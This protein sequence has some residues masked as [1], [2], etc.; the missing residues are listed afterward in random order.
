MKESKRT[1]LTIILV[2]TVSLLV[3]AAIVYYTVTTNEKYKDQRYE[4][5]FLTSSSPQRIDSESHYFFPD[6]EED[7]PR[8]LLQALLDGPESTQLVSPFPEDLQIVNVSVLGDTLSV[9]FSEHY[10][11][12]DPY[13]RNLADC[14]L[15][16]TVSALPE[17]RQVF[18]RSSDSQAPALLTADRFLASDR[19]FVTA[20]REF[21]L[22]Y[23]NAAFTALQNIS[24]PYRIHFGQSEIETVLDL[25]EHE[26]FP[27][28]ADIPLPSPLVNDAL[29]YDNVAHVDLSADLLIIQESVDADEY[30][31]RIRQNSVYLRAIV[32]TLVSL[33]DIGSVMFTF[34]N[35]VMGQYGSLDL[36]KPLTVYKF[37]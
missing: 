19:F 6:S 25:L 20:E 11:A 3:I 29:V 24:Y 14:C 2:L 13:S 30:E 15:Y 22:Y 12:L 9:F 35:T 16:Q 26:I 37:Q 21:T 31:D 36:S 27:Q 7:L 4:L 33:D 8:M 10:D 34:D 18:L 5:Y 1:W 28:Q 17:I 23:P 32:T